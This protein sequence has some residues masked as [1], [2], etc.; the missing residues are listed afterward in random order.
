MTKR[1]IFKISDEQIKQM[2][3]DGNSMQDIAKVAQDTKGLMALRRKLK[4]L[5]ID[6]RL[7]QKKYK[8]KIS[9]ASRKYSFDEH[10][11]DNIKNEHKA[12]WL[13]FLMADGYNHETKTCVAL[14][15]QGQDKEILEK[16][17]QDLK[18]TGPIYTINT[19]RKPF[20]IKEDYTELNLC[21][22]IFSKALAKVGCIQNKTYLLEF[23]KIKEDLINHFIRGY[24]DGD[25]CVSIT[26]RCDRKTGK[27][28]QFNIVGRYE[29]IKKIYDIFIKTLNITATTISQNPNNYARTIHWSGRKVVTKIL[30]YLYKDS[31]I[32]LQRKYNKY[33]QIIGNSVE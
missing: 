32:Y 3:L 11:F 29:F 15:L 2:Y 16:F 24:F 14:R 12:Y 23:P 26:N 33:L 13:G 18:Y 6:T 1:K 4:E 20:N 25:G 10:Y 21:S 30:D 27:V 7:D 31:T 22:P 17:K 19:S 28:Y 9:K 8:Y 5:G